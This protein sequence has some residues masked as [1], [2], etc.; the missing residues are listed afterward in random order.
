MKAYF[1]ENMRT[2]HIIVYAFVPFY[3]LIMV[4]LILRDHQ[5]CLLNTLRLCI[6]SFDSIALVDGCIIQRQQ[7]MIFRKKLCDRD[8]EMIL[9][10]P[11][12]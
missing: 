1:I 12:V 2:I 10:E 5:I 11:H 7:I 6:F 9:S 4:T 8:H 3:L